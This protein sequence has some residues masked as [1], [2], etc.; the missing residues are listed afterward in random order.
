MTDGED[1]ES[2]HADPGIEDL[3]L[4]VAGVDDI[5]DAVDSQ[6][7]LGNVGR[8]DHLAHAVLGLLEDF[9]LQIGGQLR[10]DGQH[11]E[12]LGAV[13]LERLELL[14][15]EVARGVD[16]LLTGHEDEHVAVGRAQMDLHGLFDGRIDVVLDGGLGEE[17][18]DGKGAAGYEEDGHEAEELRE[19]VR[20]HGGRRDDELEVLA[21]ADHV[22]QQAEQ[23]VRV[24]RTLVR[25]V[26]DHGR[27]AVQVGLGETLAQQDAVRHVLDDRRVGRAVLETDRVA[28]FVAQFDTLEIKWTRQS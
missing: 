13:G 16:V 25:L 11:A 23:H 27:V 20:V 14:L 22:A 6:A 8:H 24:E 12:R 7:R 10:V 19:L 1:L 5:L 4:A 15:D 28:D 21:A 2:V 26:H 18:L 17:D 3:E 9:R